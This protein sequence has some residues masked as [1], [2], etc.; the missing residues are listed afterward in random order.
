MGLELVGKNGAVVKLIPINAPAVPG[1]SQGFVDGLGAACQ[2]GI[3]I[4][5]FFEGYGH[6]GMGRLLVEAISPGRNLDGSIIKTPI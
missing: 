5:Y 2:L 1:Y 4:A 3:M 6:K